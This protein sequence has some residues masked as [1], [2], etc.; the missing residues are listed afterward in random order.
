MGERK[1]YKFSLKFIRPFILILGL[2]L[3]FIGL[4]FQKSIISAESIT[5][6]KEA[7]LEELQKVKANETVYE[8]QL[9]NLLKESLAIENELESINN[10]LSKVRLAAAKAKTQVMT[11]KIFAE[12]LRLQR[13]NIISELY[14]MTDDPL[15]FVLS[16]LDTEKFMSK[17]HGKDEDSILIAEKIA[18]VFELNKDLEKLAEDQKRLV[19]KLKSYQEQADKLSQKAAKIQAEIARKE[20]TLFALGS[21]RY[22]LEKYLTGL[23]KLSSN[24]NRD[25]IAWNLAKGPKFEIKGGGTEHGLGLSQYGAKGLAR[26]GKS[27]RQILLHYYQGISIKKIDK[28]PKVR[29]GIVLS[30]KGGKIEIVAGEYSLGTTTLSA[31]DT[32]IINP[33]EV[34]IYRDEDLIKKFV[35]NST[36]KI[37]P[38]SSQSIVQ[39]DYKKSYFNKYHGEIR[40]IK[41][42]KSLITVNVLPMEDYL[43]GVIP[44]EVPYTWPREAIK[45]QALAARSYAYKYLGRSGNYDMDDSTAYQVYIGAFHRTRTDH[46]VDES[47]GEVITYAGK[48]ISAYYFSTSG[49]WTENNENI[50]G[51]RPIPYLRGVEST[52]EEDSPW[53]TWYTKQYSRAKI[54]RLLASLKCGTI[55]KIKITARGVSGRVLAIKLVG[56]RAVRIISGSHFKKLINVPLGPDDEMMRSTLFGIRSVK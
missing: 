12:N 20:G 18:K 21:Q 48:I 22:N 40:I 15:F 36:Q 9:S 51:G 52:W 24:L 34:K 17:L 38:K 3:I 33:D 27:Y 30:G 47:R 35:N 43:K 25:F 49:G 13:K 6:E 46:L 1:A 14:I 54:S 42:G 7:V 31:G 28:N 55:K 2:I 45:S 4:V 29:I 16:F 26:Q 37:I 19:V 56:D 8:S 23:T 53:W 5:E 41:K 11:N 32:I 44:G 50:W 39:I 10:R